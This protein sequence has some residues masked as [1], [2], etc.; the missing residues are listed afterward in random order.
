M[1][2]S[3]G[4]DSSEREDLKYKGYLAYTR[5]KWY[6]VWEVFGRVV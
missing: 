1:S 5:Y 4:V 3:V 6:T 2:G